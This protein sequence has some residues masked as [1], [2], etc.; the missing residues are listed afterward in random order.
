MLRRPPRSTHCISSAASDVYKRQ[1]QRRVHGLELSD[2]VLH[3]CVRSLMQL[4]I[5]LCCWFPFASGEQ[6][7]QQREA[8][9][10]RPPGF[11]DILHNSTLALAP[12]PS[13]P[14]FDPSHMERAVDSWRE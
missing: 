9:S 4:Q 2:D 5:F 14:S 7:R 8:L 3:T 13:S 12:P 10:P 11:L 1:Y 6:W